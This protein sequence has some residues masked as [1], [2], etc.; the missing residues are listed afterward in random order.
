MWCVV[1]K[2]M[3]CKDLRFVVVRSECNVTILIG[4]S[5]NA[6]RKSLPR[7]YVD[8]AWFHT[9]NL[10]LSSHDFPAF[11]WFTV[12]VVYWLRGLIVGWDSLPF[13]G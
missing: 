1:R 9:L 6:G 8:R 7:P 12:F 11:V 10:P 5:D 2:C 13:M 3:Q 4:R